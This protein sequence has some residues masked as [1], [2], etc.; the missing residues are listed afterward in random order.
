MLWSSGSVTVPRNRTKPGRCD[1]LLFCGLLA[2]QAAVLVWIDWRTA[3]TWDEWGHLP[4]GLYHLQYGEYEPYCVNPPIVRMVAALPVWAA[5]GGMPWLRLPNTPGARPEW[6]LS[7]VFLRAQGERCFQVFPLARMALIPVSLLGTFLL[8]SIGRRFYGAAS[9]WVAGVLWCFSPTA[10]AFGGT[11]APDVSAAVF[12]LLAAYRFYIWLRMGTWSAA[13]W[14]AIA[15]AI[16]LLCKSTWLILPVVFALLWCMDRIKSLSEN[17]PRRRGQAHFAPQ[18]PQNEPVPG[19]PGIGSKYRRRPL[20]TAALQWLAGIAL[21]WLVIH[22]VYDFRGALRPLRSFTFRSQALTGNADPRSEPG[23]RFADSW[24]GNIPMPLPAD[25]IQGIDIQRADF[26]GQRPSYLFG[27]WQDHGWWYYYL[28]GIFL[29]EPVAVWGLAALLL[30]GIA[31]RK[32]RR[33]RWRELVLMAPGLAVLIFVSTQTGFSHH[34][35]YVLPFFPCLYLVVARSA[36]VEAKWIK[37]TAFVLCGWY[38]ASSAATLPRSY[39]FFSE[40]V[41]GADEG[42][43]YLGDSNL[44]WGQDLITLRDW[45]AENPDKRPIWLLYAPWTLDFHHLG[46]DAA[47]GRSR[48]LAG[49]PNAAGWWAVFATPL[50]EPEF[51]WFREHRATIRLSPTLKLIYVSPA[52]LEALSGNGRKEI[53]P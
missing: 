28:A 25:Y 44:D 2:L 31:R 11:I 22:A 30:V 29:K 47:D 46:V 4:S 33:V 15:T 39:A 5:G 37:V 3:P 10:L 7:S 52:D 38:A 1:W 50:I 26:E 17:R 45:A 35:R 18:T 19:G 8:W 20:A 51:T 40:A 21:A 9:G 14:L 43:R 24:L 36:A 48:V 49:R 42:W 27:T 6:L 41:G 32:Q 53:S 13:I 23:N 12:G 34:L 16:A